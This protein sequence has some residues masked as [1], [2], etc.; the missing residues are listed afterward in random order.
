ME[1][2]SE[3]NSIYCG[4]LTPQSQNA[5]SITQNIIEYFD[6][7]CLKAVGCDGT[8][9]NTGIKGGIIAL[10]EK[11]L[12]KLLQ[13]IICVL[14]CIELPLSHLFRSIDG[15]ISGPNA[16]SGPI[17]QLISNCEHQKVYDFEP[18]PS[19]FEFINLHNLSNQTYLRDILLAVKYGSV[20]NS[21]AN[22]NQ[23]ERTS[24]LQYLVKTSKL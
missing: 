11:D 5:N 14:H 8:A 6:Y 4:H 3:S 22:R 12:G 13:W 1:K 20:N 24:L 10:L 9:V 23:H 7:S 16:F 21:L 19:D 18:I 2:Y 17:G 15:T